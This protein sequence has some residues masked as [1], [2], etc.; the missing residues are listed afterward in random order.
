MNLLNSLHPLGVV[1]WLHEPQSTMVY[2]D[3]GFPRRVGRYQPVESP[4]LSPVCWNYRD[5]ERFL[6]RG[7]D[8]N[9]PVSGTTSTLAE[10]ATLADRWLHEPQLISNQPVGLGFPHL[11]VQYQPG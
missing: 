3:L 4:S 9:L 10:G 5:M 11:A 2:P 1:R 8:L 6:I 7:W